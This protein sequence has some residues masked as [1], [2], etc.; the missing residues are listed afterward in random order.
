[1]D[2]VNEGLN[3]GPLSGFGAGRAGGE[4]GIQR[5]REESER[6]RAREER[7]GGRRGGRDGRDGGVKRGG[8]GRWLVERVDGTDRGQG[9][10][11]QSR[12]NRAGQSRATGDIRLEGENKER[13]RKRGR[14]RRRIR[15][16]TTT[17][18][19]SKANA[20]SIHPSSHQSWSAVPLSQPLQGQRSKE[21][22]DQK[23]QEERAGPGPGEH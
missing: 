8:A 20:T 11:G 5:E 9:R 15:I 19:T 17:I 13:T 23:E 22:K 21:P 10:P 12:V 3:W 14:G 6:R 1:M 18:T 16:I 7:E 4:G 2:G